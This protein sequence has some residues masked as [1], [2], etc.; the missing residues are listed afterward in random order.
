M[1]TSPDDKLKQAAPQSHKNVEFVKEKTRG[2]TLWITNTCLT[3]TRVVYNVLD[4]ICMEIGFQ[5]FVIKFTVKRDDHGSYCA[6]HQRYL[7][8]KVALAFKCKN[9]F[10]TSSYNSEK[11]GWNWL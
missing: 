4:A 5:L 3:E 10:Q 7:G 8:H 2:A 6:T 11:R 1:Y 9:T